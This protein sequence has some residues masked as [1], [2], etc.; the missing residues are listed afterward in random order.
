LGREVLHDIIVQEVL[1][2][3]VSTQN[4]LHFGRMVLLR[5]VESNAARLELPKVNGKNNCDLEDPGIR[6]K[7]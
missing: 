2:T 5:E 4:V 1:V 3:S 7:V 6:V